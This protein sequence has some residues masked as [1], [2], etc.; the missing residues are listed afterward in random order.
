MSKRIRLE[1]NARDQ[2]DEIA[3]WTL[4]T[5]GSAQAQRYED[6]LFERLEKLAQ[7][8]AHSRPVA[9]QDARRMMRAGQHIVIFT[10]AGETVTILAF[11]H[12][13]SDI[14]KHLPIV[15]DD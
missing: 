2:L 11:L 13:A 1:K 10:E 7:G 15:K 6:L 5:F 4:Q 14:L 9:P 12:S 3:L 8:T